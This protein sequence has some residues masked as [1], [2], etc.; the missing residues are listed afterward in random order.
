M[1]QKTI[2]ETLREEA[3]GFKAI[4]AAIFTTFNF[5]PDF[6]ENNVL[7]ALFDID[8]H[9]EE[10]R[11][12]KVNH[13]LL[14]TNVCVL[15][16]ASTRPKGGGL[17]RY[18]RVG[19][20][21]PGRFFHPKLMILA[22]IHLDDE[23]PWIYLTVSSA[24]LTLS[25]WGK[26][27]EIMGEVWIG[28]NRQRLYSEVRGALEWLRETGGGKPRTQ[29]PAI[30]RC[31]AVMDSMGADFPE[32]VSKNASFYFSP[33]HEEGFW[34]FL[35]A[36]QTAKWDDLMVFSPY[37]GEVKKSLQLANCRTTRLVPAML[38]EGHYGLGRSGIAECDDL[39]LLK[40]TRL[41]NNRFWH[42]KTYFLTRGDRMRVGV[43]SANFTGAGLSGGEKGNVEA[44]L[45]FDAE[46]RDLEKFIPDLVDLPLDD[47]Q[48]PDD[49][50]KDGPEPAPLVIVVVY[51]W[52]ARQY[53]I[54]FEPE[55]DPEAREYRLALPGL[56]AV[57]LD[58]VRGSLT[59]SD[60]KGP[61]KSSAFRLRYFRLK[62]EIV[63]D[64]LINEINVESSDKQYFHPMSLIEILESWR[65]PSDTPP[66]TK[67][68]EGEDSEG[69]ADPSDQDKED[70]GEQPSSTGFDVLN[71][72]ELYRS[73]FALRSRLEEARRDRDTGRLLGFLVTRPDSIYRVAKQ[74]ANDATE[75]LIS[76]FVVLL[77][78]QDLMNEYRKGI[79]GFNPSFRRD[80][81]NWTNCLRGLVRSLPQA[82]QNDLPLKEAL[83]W[84]EMELRKAWRT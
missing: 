77:E 28:S 20:F 29:I 15:Y 55:I 21:R 36:G 72:Y 13:R 26:N 37:W 1:T 54:F 9:R 51:D 60:A 39:D 61:V 62:A 78:C 84:F 2:R 65:L 63:F 81:M 70:N 75:H 23:R 58:D 22:G 42:A 27:Q 68:T 41:E 30:E 57:C 53:R 38:E 69:D 14:N 24:N 83:S 31:L 66:M 3:V 48:L 45:V 59:V 10:R 56:D 73:V 16:D 50:E 64:G 8:D 11:R 80:V 17:F 18:Q 33:L 67:D 52:Q 5:H 74:A 71:F 34:P 44:M 40:L 47:P 82:N 43:G 6:F 35:Q 49:N 4:E 7:P 32:G 46:A 12:V 25:G 76:R 79:P 19:I